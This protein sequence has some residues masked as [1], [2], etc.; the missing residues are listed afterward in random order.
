MPPVLQQ[1]APPPHVHL[2]DCN[3]ACIRGLPRGQPVSDACDAHAPMR[4]V[5]A[6]RVMVTA[7]MAVENSTSARFSCSSC[8]G[9]KASNSL[10]LRSAATGAGEHA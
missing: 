1:P 10:A 9:V 6:H 2:Y 8:S 4:S 5:L 7:H 3:A